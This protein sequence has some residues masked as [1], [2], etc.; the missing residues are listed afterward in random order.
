MKISFD[1]IKP[2]YLQIAEAI[3]DDIIYGKLPE[4]EACYSQLVI[5]KELNV[6]PAT[7]AKGIGL[8]VQKGI[9]VKQRGLSMIVAN[10]AKNDLLKQ[11]KEGGLGDLINQLIN[12]ANKLNLSYSD[13]IKLLEQKYKEGESHEK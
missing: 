11:R 12:E 5:A 3:E 6:N 7:A 1:S 13:L 8:L 4:G 9:L 10:G 2:V